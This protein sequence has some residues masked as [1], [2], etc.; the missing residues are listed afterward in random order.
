MERTLEIVDQA[1]AAIGRDVAV[2]C[3]ADGSAAAR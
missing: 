3:G 1:L 2:P